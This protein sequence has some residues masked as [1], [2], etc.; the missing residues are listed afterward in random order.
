M[1]QNAS[2]SALGVVSYEIGHS[3]GLPGRGEA[4]Q[5]QARVPSLG[6]EYRARTVDEGETQ[7]VVLLKRPLGAAGLPVDDWGP[8]T[9]RAIGPDADDWLDR[10]DAALGTR[11]GDVYPR[12]D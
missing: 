10:V 6:A 8:V 7:Y 1:P 4:T 11:F 5:V 2:P 12:E 9:P 3:R